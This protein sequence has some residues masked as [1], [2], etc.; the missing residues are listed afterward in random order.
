MLGGFGEISSVLKNAIQ[1]RPVRVGHRLGS[2]QN[3]PIGSALGSK[4]CRSDKF[5]RT[6]H[7]NMQ[8]T[9]Q[10]CIRWQG[11]NTFTCHFFDPFQV[12]NDTINL[13]LDWSDLDE[14][15]YPTLDADFIYSNTKKKRSLKGLRKE[16]HH[17]KPL[18]SGGRIYTWEFKEF[19]RPFKVLV[20]WLASVPFSA[21]FGLS[22]SAEVIKSTEKTSK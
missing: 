5:L 8:S 21:K 9:V 12:E 16:A 1:T 20:R 11:I 4:I 15:G 7:R 17:T 22:V 6:E 10:S 18:G 14:N 13:R 19:K 3:D 2:K